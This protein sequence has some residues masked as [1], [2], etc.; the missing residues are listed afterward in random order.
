ML[1]TY[2]I[3]KSL[4]KV[5]LQDLEQLVIDRANKL[6]KTIKVYAACNW[7]SACRIWFKVV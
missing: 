3:N 5:T 7:R 2:G 4:S 6:G 1:D